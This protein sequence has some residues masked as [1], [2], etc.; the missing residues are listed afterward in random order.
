MK[1]VFMCSSGKSN[2]VLGCFV[3]YP[4]TALYFQDKDANKIAPEMTRKFK[5]NLMGK[6][7]MMS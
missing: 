6:Q 3:K 2:L 1:R 4:Y 7:I 5:L